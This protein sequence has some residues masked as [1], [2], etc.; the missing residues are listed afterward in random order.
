MQ[1][2]TSDSQASHILVHVSLLT[3]C[4]ETLR[5]LQPML[6][7]HDHTQP[8]HL[9]Q[10]ESFY[11][12][13]CWFIAIRVRWSCSSLRLRCSAASRSC[14]CRALNSPSSAAYQFLSILT[15]HGVAAAYNV[16]GPGISLAGELFEPS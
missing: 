16:K 5:G 6:E 10:S 2:T 14:S 9:S 7:V 12:H 15:T 4:D 3:H 8:N 13:H 11:K 1:L